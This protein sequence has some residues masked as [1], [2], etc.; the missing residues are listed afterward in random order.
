MLF[1]LFLY[2]ATANAFWTNRFVQTNKDIY[3]ISD[4]DP[5]VFIDP[6]FV[7]AQQYKLT[8]ASKAQTMT[9]NFHKWLNETWGLDVTQAVYNP[10]TTGYDF[11]TASIFP[12]TVI[13]PDD[14]VIVDTRFPLRA[15]GKSWIQHAASWFVRFN[16]SYIVS[17]GKNVGYTVDTQSALIYGNIY[18]T[19]RNA[20]WSNPLF[21]ETQLCYTDVTAK[22]FNNTFI[23][24]GDFGGLDSVIRFTCIDNTSLPRGAECLM[25]VTNMYTRHNNGSIDEAKRASLTC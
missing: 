2:F 20:D 25:S 6:N 15:L 24:G 3:S 10:A 12:T 7:I 22:F 18:Y 4:V 19:K 17:V 21:K 5:S 16:T 1:L 8:T 13:D 11:S 14:I 9:Q 23:A